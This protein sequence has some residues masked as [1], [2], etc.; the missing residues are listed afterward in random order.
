VSI[1][2]NSGGPSNN[3]GVHD[4]VAVNIDN[5]FI[6]IL[7]SDV[8]TGLGGAGT[9]QTALIASN[10]ANV[11]F[12]NGRFTPSFGGLTRV[13]AKQNPGAIIKI[14]NSELRGTTVGAPSCFAVFQQN[15][16]AAACP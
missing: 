13:A 4:N 12:A 10:T 15:Y 14:D 2:A 8:G 11:R 1:G 7:N 9:N 5:G 16:T 6:H 3:P